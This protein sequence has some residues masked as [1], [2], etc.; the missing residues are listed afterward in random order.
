MNIQEYWYAVL[1]QDERTIKSFFC[2]DGYVNWHNT[3]EHFTVDEFIR[4][5]CEYPDLWD[6][7]IERIEVIGNTVITV[8]AVFSQD[9]KLRFHV[10]SFIVLRE[11]KIYSV[12]EYWG[13][14]G[15]APM[16]RQS[17]N[18]GSPIIK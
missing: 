5:N 12:D 1:R 10:T 7:S 6:G 15:E 11:D 4:A 16:W 18:L 17:L 8:V 3:N 14:D 13:N 2:D 9:K